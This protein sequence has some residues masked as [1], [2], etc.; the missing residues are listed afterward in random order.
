MRRTVVMRALIGVFGLMQA[1][2]PAM[3]SFAEANLGAP[4]AAVAHIEDET[5]RSCIPE[6]GDDCTLCRA[7]TDGG[8]PRAAASLPALGYAARA[9]RAASERSRPDRSDYSSLRSRAPPT[10]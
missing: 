1:G 4:S 7:L 8:Q 10:A 6:H 9:P 5:Q 3:L 2:S